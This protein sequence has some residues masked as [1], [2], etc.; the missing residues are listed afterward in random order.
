MDCPYCKTK[1]R[2]VPAGVSKKTGKKYSAFYICDN[3]GYT[4]QAEGQKQIGARH[5]LAVLLEIRDILKEI[6]DKE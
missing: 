1:L 2:F 6:R 3:C 5:L 4:K